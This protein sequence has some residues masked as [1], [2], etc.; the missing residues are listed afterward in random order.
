MSKSDRYILS[1]MFLLITR[2]IG[3]VLAIICNPG[4]GLKDYVDK[5]TSDVEN[6]TGQL[7]KWAEK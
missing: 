5:W 3:V 1:K 6:F 4:Q 7:D 2:G